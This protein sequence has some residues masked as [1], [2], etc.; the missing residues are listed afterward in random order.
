MLALNVLGAHPKGLFQQRGGWRGPG[1]ASGCV[2]VV[3]SRCQG[4]GDSVAIQGSVVSAV[5]KGTLENVA[6]L[7]A[8]EQPGAPG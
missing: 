2:P 4:R 1:Q 5:S 3:A 8:Q 7:F 6:V